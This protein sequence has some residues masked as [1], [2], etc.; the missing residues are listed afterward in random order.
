MIPTDQ[1]EPWEQ[2]LFADN[3]PVEIILRIAHMLLGPDEEP[4]PE[5]AAQDMTVYRM[6][7]VSLFQRGADYREIPWPLRLEHARLTGQ[8]ERQPLRRPKGTDPI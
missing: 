7:A 6:L 1:V 8:S 3:V 2:P 4:S 5:Q